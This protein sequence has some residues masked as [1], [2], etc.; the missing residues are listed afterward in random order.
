MFVCFQSLLMN[1]LLKDALS[2][3]KS[4][5]FPKN[6]NLV[7]DKTHFGLSSTFCVFPE[8]QILFLKFIYICF[9]L[10][11]LLLEL[12]PFENYNQVSV[13][14]SHRMMGTT[15]DKGNPSQTVLQLRWSSGFAQVGCEI[16]ILAD[17]QH[18][19]GPRPLATRSSWSCF[20]HRGWSSWAREVPSNTNDAMININQ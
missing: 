18:E 3:S 14:H 10:Y 9:F 13:V 11:K 2:H 19:T 7:V 15:N 5:V 4:P 8:L 16:C 1:L 17:N 20:G 12:N 6:K